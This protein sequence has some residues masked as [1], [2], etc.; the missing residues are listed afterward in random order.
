MDHC[1]GNNYNIHEPIC[2]PK[3][4][5]YNDVTS[6]SLPPLKIGQPWLEV[7]CLYVLRGRLHGEFQP[8]NQAGEISARLPQQIFSKDA[9]DYM[10]KVSAPGLN[11]AWSEK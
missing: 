10:K 11:S 3:N 7:E 8:V 4:I 1:I 5:R 6:W 9:C 2:Q